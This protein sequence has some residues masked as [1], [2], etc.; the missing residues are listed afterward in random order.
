M[1]NRDYW[2][3]TDD[4]NFVV[5]VPAFKDEII[6]VLDVRDGDVPSNLQF[7]LTNTFNDEM[8]NEVRE[9]ATGYGVTVIDDKM[10]VTFRDK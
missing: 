10:A 8:M 3:Q 2:F 6:V 1:A 9:I 4:E 7:N 5:Y